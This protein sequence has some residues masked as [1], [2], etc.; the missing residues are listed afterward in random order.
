MVDH[1]AVRQ[2]VT[3]IRERLGMTKVAFADSIG[4]TKSNYGQVEKGNRKL[5]VDQ[6]YNIFIVY[7]VPMEYVLAGQE[8]NLPEKFR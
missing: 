8:A 3:F 1:D 4:I 7:G 2:R 5:S 6:I